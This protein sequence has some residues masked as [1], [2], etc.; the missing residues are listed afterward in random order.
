M[1]KRQN[2]NYTTLYE[3]KMAYENEMAQP[4]YHPFM[5]VKQIIIR[6]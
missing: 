2:I 1:L 5:A 6:I 4:K 3:V